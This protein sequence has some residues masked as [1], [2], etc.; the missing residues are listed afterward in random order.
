MLKYC[1]IYG[2]TP[3]SVAMNSWAVKMGSLLSNRESLTTPVCLTRS[4]GGVDETAA[5]R[6]P[7]TYH[8]MRHLTYAF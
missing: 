4:G 3:S 5:G 8:A 2:E 7:E 6:N 1:L